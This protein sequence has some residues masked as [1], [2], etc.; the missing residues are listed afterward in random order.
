MSFLVL[1]FRLFV[2]CFAVLFLCLLVTPRF[3]SHFFSHTGELSIKTKRIDDRL[4]FKRARRRQ[5]K[6]P[7]A[8]G[9]PL[10]GSRI[11]LWG[12][13]LENWH[14]STYPT[15]PVSQVV[16]KSNMCGRVSVQFRIPDCNDCLIGDL[17]DS[18]AAGQNKRPVLFSTQPCSFH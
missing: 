4:S 6:M 11:T 1:G 3:L 18:G 5:K 13:P 7:F 12:G 15:L 17:G 9:Q 16:P 2:L 8:Q 10:H 14:E